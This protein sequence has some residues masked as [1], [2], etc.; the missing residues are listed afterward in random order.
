MNWLALVFIGVIA[1]AL[2]GP[3]GMLGSR[4]GNRWQWVS[5][6]I[7]VG[8]GVCGLVAACAVLFGYPAET[9]SF[10]A[11]APA[12]TVNLRIG[13]LSAFFLIPIFTIGALS[14]VYGLGYW[15]QSRHPRT[16]RKLRLW[17]GVLIA[18]MAMLTLCQNSIDFLVAWEMMAI[19]TFFLIVTEDQKPAARQAAWV[20]LVATHLGTLLLLALFAILRAW[21]CRLRIKRAAT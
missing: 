20:Y 18:G 4:S 3:A 14:S 1:F 19:S 7:G 9:L 16:G 11:A 12:M 8:G 21:P 5:A 17:Y 6:G 10:A 2:S 15:Q 13:P